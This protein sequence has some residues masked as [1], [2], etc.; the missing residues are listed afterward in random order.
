MAFAEAADIVKPCVKH[1]SSTLEGLKAATWFGG[2]FQ[3]R[4]PEAIPGQNV[5]TFQSAEAASYD[6]DAFL[7]LNY[8]DNILS[9]HSQKKA[10][11]TGSNSPS[12]V[13]NS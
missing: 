6:D 13:V 10:G 8:S 11:P 7:H 2:L 12:S 5:A 1:T 3:N 9:F 4:H